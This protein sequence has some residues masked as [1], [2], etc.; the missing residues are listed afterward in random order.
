MD[1]PI[2]AAWIGVDQ[3]HSMTGD[4]PFGLTGTR[5]LRPSRGAGVAPR[6]AGAPGADGARPP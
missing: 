3:V 4:D 5:T 6:Q 1:L 2:T